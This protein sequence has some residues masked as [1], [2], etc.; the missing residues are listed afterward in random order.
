MTFDRIVWIVLD[1][2]GI[3]AMPDA[4]SNY[5]DET[6][7][8]RLS[9]SEVTGAKGEARYAHQILRLVTDQSWTPRGPR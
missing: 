6:I 1:S 7:T 3:G 4:A 2:V 9:V 8:L 5:G